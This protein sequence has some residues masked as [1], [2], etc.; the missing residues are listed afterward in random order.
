VYGTTASE[1]HGAVGVWGAALGVTGGLSRGVYGTTA[2]ETHG[3]VGV[4][5]A[6]LGDAGRIYGV[7]GDTDSTN[8]HAA[9]VLGVD[10]SGLTAALNDFF[11]KTA[12]VRG[13][14]SDDFG[15]VG[16]TDSP[17]GQA[18]VAGFVVD[19]DGSSFAGGRLGANFFGP[20][21][22]GVYS[23]GDYGGTGAKYFVEPHSQRADLVI[24][25]VALEGP[26][27][28]TYFRGRGKIQN[29]LATIEVP[30]DF[31]LVTSAEGLSIQVTPIREMATI[32]VMEIGLDRIV[33]KGSR[34]VEFFYTVNGVRRSHEHLRPIVPGREF[35]PEGPEARLPAYLTDVQK[36]M[37]VSNGTYTADGKVNPQTARRLGWDKAWE[38]RSTPK[39]RSD[40]PAQGGQ[41]P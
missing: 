29:G 14:S 9:G 19:S 33:V 31:R 15:V 26:E 22:Y 1:T 17:G 12:G 11:T 36:A 32:A 34:N 6:A 2:S 8:S 23:S 27:S 25:Y 39:V 7:R 40:P 35:M 37:L 28:G 41:T 3:A 4:W 20:T 18:G 24:R 38:S 10:A 5:G 21:F 13:E 30:E 16:F